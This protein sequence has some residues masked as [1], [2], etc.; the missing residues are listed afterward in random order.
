MI[1]CGISPNIVTF[2]SMIDILCKE[3]KTGK[4]FDL[5]ELMTRKGVKPNIFTYNSLIQG[6]FHSGQWKEATSLFNR[7][8]SKGVNPD[9]VTFSS[10]SMLYARKRGMKKPLPCWN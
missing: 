4:A 7:M 5:L 9:V 8:M 2:S 3:G 10:L 1:D 6:L